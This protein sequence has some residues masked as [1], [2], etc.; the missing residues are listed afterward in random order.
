MYWA[1]MSSD[2]SDAESLRQGLD[3][4]VETIKA[5]TADGSLSIKG[6]GAILKSG[7]EAISALVRTFSDMQANYEPL[8]EGLQRI[9]DEHIAPLDIPFVPEWI[10]Q[11]F[12]D[13]PARDFIRWYVTWIYRALEG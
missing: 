1:A 10:E 8:I 13:V 9:Y 6:L 11:R 12:I 5:A 7:G 3:E 2:S 4:L